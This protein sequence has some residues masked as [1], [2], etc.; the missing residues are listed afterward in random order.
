MS[1][2]WAPAGLFL[3]RTPLLPRAVLAGLAD[4]SVAVEDLLADPVVSEALALSVP[5]VAGEVRRADGRLEESLRRTLV[6]Y[7]VRMSTRCTP[8]GLMAGCSWGRVADGVSGVTLPARADHRRSVRP[9]VRF[10]AQ[11]VDELAADL[12]PTTFG[13]L[14]LRR[15]PDARA[16]P[17]RI[18]LAR[19][20][21]TADGDV[22]EVV[23]VG[24]TEPL[25]LVLDRADKPVPA[26]ELVAAL[27]EGGHTA[28][29]ED[30][31][32]F[33]RAVL[34]AGLLL[35]DLHAATTGPQLHELHAGWDRTV[36]AAVPAPRRRA[37]GRLARL[38]GS[39][40]GDLPPGGA[41]WAGDERCDFGPGPVVDLWRPATTAL[42]APAD[43]EVLGAS[44]DLL[45]RLSLW[46]PHAAL[47]AFSEAFLDRYDE[48]WELDT[49]PLGRRSGIPLLEALDPETGVDFGGGENLDPAPVIDR[50]RFPVT[51]APEPRHPL[52]QHLLDAVVRHAA[53]GR[54]V[55][56]LGA[57]DLAVL[58]T[59]DP[60][61]FPDSVAVTASRCVVDG[62]AAWVVHGV[63]G[64]AWTS[65]IARFARADD[66]LLEAVREQ[67]AQEEAE[68]PEVTV[69]DFVHQ[70]PGRAANLAAH[71]SL[72]GHEADLFGT[73]AGTGRP[74]HLEDL[75]LTMR[76]G[77][78]LLF[79]AETGREVVPR[80]PTSYNY[81]ISPFPLVRFLGALQ[82]GRAGRDLGWDW[83]A[84][85][86]APVLPR[87]VADGVVLS[88]GR[89]RLA[90]ADLADLLEARDDEVL[91]RAARTLA[92]RHRLPDVVGL[93]V[94]DMV[95]P[96][97]LASPTLLRQLVAEARRGSDV[98]LTEVFHE[99]DGA[100]LV[101]GPEG[102]YAHELVVPFRRRPTSP[103]LVAQVDASRAA[104]PSGARAVGGAGRPVVHPPG[105]E[106]LYAELFCGSADA[107][108]L[109]GALSDELASWDLR[110][111]F[112]V[113]Y[114]T[115]G[116]HLRL[117]LQ[118]DP[119]HL[120][121][122]VLPGLR[123]R[124]E[125]DE[126]VTRVARWTVTGYRPEVDRYGG[127]EGLEVCHDVFHAD[128]VAF[129]GLLGAGLVDDPDLR[130]RVAL[131]A[132]LDLLDGLGVA[133]EDQLRLVEVA[134]DR[135]RWEQRADRAFLTAVGAQYREH[136][137]L[138]ED[139]LGDG[140]SPLPGI[141]DLL[142]ARAVRL[143]DAGA[144]LRLLDARG[145]L[146]RPVD[147]IAPS[148]LHLTFN[149]FL[150]SQQRPQETVLY[151]YLSRAL[152]SRL[153]RRR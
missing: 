126:L 18:R 105:S 1:G 135:F 133:P 108:V 51:P 101:S 112:F 63:G 44:L 142:G 143:A 129:A 128:S 89:W 136:R 78:L 76:A 147:A 96:L 54:D 36:L 94:G 56:Q 58:A 113:R 144:R 92:E 55:W 102:A 46:Q 120:L 59:S 87:V 146:N 9:D 14:H 53:A 67:C 57:D 73:S 77:R 125:Q 19:L 64:P 13:S 88:P 111:W 31:T 153:A 50:L 118:A 79:S 141:A 75:R 131:R 103:D 74:V 23:E 122:T 99:R 97:D 137:A 4:G 30:A 130:W 26:H 2:D 69:V 3:V 21:P 98:R 61:E 110:R 152:R 5:S 100:P 37:L 45:A 109:L 119:D 145:S 27:V 150:L 138:V 149:R 72:R 6:R 124:L 24:R 132:G 41:D 104:V 107:D 33:L 40:L 90:P 139:A 42:L 114:R 43:A 106:W 117:R 121:R 11:V 20:R 28:D 85:R 7:L 151:D 60:G 49:L 82:H 83:G 84:L 25:D 32:D 47:Q 8:L 29:V 91:V 52:E 68:R 65:R 116:W 127:P 95:L 134:R 140:W 71:P 16:L 123:R 86:D 70:P 15:H 66:D 48:Q 38:D 35:S 39:R 34:G 17:G 81:E 62:A 22:P 115:T 93:T 12:D 80:L 10:G 148:L